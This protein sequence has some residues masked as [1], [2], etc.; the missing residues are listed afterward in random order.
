MEHGWTI[1]VAR[2]HNIYG[3][4]QDIEQILRREYKALTLKSR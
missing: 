3:H 1:V 4:D 2:K